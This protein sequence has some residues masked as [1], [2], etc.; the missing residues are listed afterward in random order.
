MANPPALLDEELLE[1]FRLMC[2]QDL[3]M[4]TFSEDAL[5]TDAE[6]QRHL[7]TAFYAFHHYFRA[8]PEKVADFQAGD[9][10]GN[11]ECPEVTGIYRSVTE[12]GKDTERSLHPIDILVALPRTQQAKATEIKNE[13]D[14]LYRLI[15]D[16]LEGLKGW[17]KREGAVERRLHVLGFV[18]LGHSQNPITVRFLLHLSSLSEKKQVSVRRKLDS[19]MESNPYGPEADLLFGDEID[20][21]IRN[22]EAANP[23]VPQGEI[24]LDQEDNVCEYREGPCR[25]MFVN[26]RAASLRHLWKTSGARGLLAQ[27]LRYYVKMPRVD[28]AMF[29]T[30]ELEP[31]NFWYL[32]N[33]LTV[34]CDSFEIEGKTLKLRNFS[35]VNGG[36]TTHNIGT[37]EDL[38]HDFALPCKVIAMEGRDRVS[39]PADRR[40]DLIAEVCTATNSQKPIKASEAIAHLAEIRA[41]RH[42]LKQDPTEAVLLLTKRGETLDKG[43]YPFPWQSVKAQ[44]LG[45]LLLSFIYQRPCTARNKTKDLFEEKTIF[46]LVF[47]YQQSDG[48]ACFPPSRFVQDLLLI[49]AA[50]KD[51]QTKWK[52]IG[53]Y[54]V[55]IKKQRLSDLSKNG[56]FLLVACVGALCKLHTHD[57]LND[58]IRRPGTLKDRRLLGDY[59]IAFPFL[60]DR[61]FTHL[62]APDGD[63]QTL[64][65][66]CLERFVLV[67]YQDFRKNVDPTITCTNFAKSD[68]RYLGYIQKALL[69]EASEGFV[70]KELQL[71]DRVF[72][73][74]TNTERRMLA[75][76]SKRHPVRWLDDMSDYIDDLILRLDNA[77]ANMSKPGTYA[78]APTHAT[79]RKV[80]RAQPT[81]REALYATPLTLTQIK[82]YGPTLLE[83]L[84]SAEKELGAPIGKVAEASQ[85]E[86]DE[87]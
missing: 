36:Q 4:R 46:S 10:F 12:D 29:R 40:E 63:F 64:L 47:N 75:E 60:A 7:L 41:L 30:M 78:K 13:I 70:L 81:T 59:D 77:F 9:L 53:R 19:L 73:V 54:T 72:R 67:G 14:R 20:S 23:F 76:M 33:G 15:R 28:S 86:E 38:T 65:D 32:N 26:I 82:V 79:L 56:M 39:L 3:R 80:I 16:Y 31:T 17:I 85:E 44:L 52:K 51:F 5:A 21:E 45:Q 34:V 66:L 11:T 8:D 71:F 37:I 50:I 83:V 69:R 74:P 35:I 62:S 25:A 48:Y 42:A 2:E 18:G 55:D 27:N 6:S 57:A 61:D 24:Q 1:N 22:T 84:H 43:A 58:A 87:A 49:H 68:D